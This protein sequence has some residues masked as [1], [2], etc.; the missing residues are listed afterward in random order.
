M[1]KVTLQ[2][3]LSIFMVVPC[4]VFPLGKSV[5]AIFRYVGDN[6]DTIKQFCWS[7][8]MWL[9][10]SEENKAMYKLA[11][12]HLESQVNDPI[13][14]EQ[15]RP[16]T[17]FACKRPLLLDDWY[18]MFNQPNVELVIGKPVR[19]TERGILTKSPAALTDKERAEVPTGAYEERGPRDDGVETEREVDV[20]I[21]GTGRG[22]LLRLSNA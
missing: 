5:E 2:I 17:E 7:K 6:A 13:V 20:I 19:I 4:L 16:T 3:L 10:G 14:R 8:N 12:S 1:D 18:P 22:F 11:I 9:S 15:L 21:W